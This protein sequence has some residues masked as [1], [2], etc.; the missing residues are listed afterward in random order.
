ML[1]SAQRPCPCGRRERRCHAVARPRAQ[2]ADPPTITSR[3]APS[4][5]HSRQQRLRCLES[6]FSPATED[7]EEVAAL[8]EESSWISWFCSLRHVSSSASGGLYHGRIQSLVASAV[9][10]PTKDYALNPMSCPRD[11]ELSEEQHEY[12]ETVQMLYGSSTSDTS[13]TAKGLNSTCSR[14]SRAADFGRCPQEV[15]WQPCL[16]V[17]TRPSCL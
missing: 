2:L 4:G 5:A 12:V 11:E 14:S 17:E 13:L 9:K 7:S 8:V 1:S 16:P 15:Q 10:S 3:R 6:E